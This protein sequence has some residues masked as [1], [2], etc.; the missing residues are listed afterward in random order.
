MERENLVPRV[1]PKKVCL[2]LFL[3][4]IWGWPLPCPAT[5]GPEGQVLSEKESPAGEK[6]PTTAGP[7]V[8]DTTVPIREGKAN[9]E[10]RWALGFT[11]GSFNPHWRRVSARGDFVSLEV[12]VKFTYGFA[13]NWEVYTIIPY[14][15][16]WAGNV[17]PSG[18]K[19]ERSTDFGGLRDVNLTFKYL[20]LEETP[21]GPAVAGLFGVN[22]PTGHCRRL[23]PGR[24]GQDQL[25]FGAYTF[26]LG[27]DLY[28]YV[29]P[30]LLYGNIWY[31]MST[32]ATVAGEPVF[33]RDYVTV[34]L[35]A[36]WA[37]TGPWV[38]VLEFYSQWDGGRLFGVRSN[39]A[40]AALL[41]VV[42]GLECIM[43]PRWSW[44]LG[45]AIDLAG[46]NNYLKYTP[47][48]TFYYNFN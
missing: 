32:D 11:G 21:K 28:K 17:S 14:L 12:P 46:R 18:P 42:P 38:A 29:K 37:L 22:F 10:V 25:G 26:T 9:L 40:P 30:F 41:G 16:N 2:C 19:G 24:L 5:Q 7:V 34:N 47:I 36:E 1:L 27:F 39:L 8:G 33:Y 3:G 13:K 23:N 48:F 6:A 45:V 43:S 20:L 4:L 44:T 15:Y 35:A 31:S